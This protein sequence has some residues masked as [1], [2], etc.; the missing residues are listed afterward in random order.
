MAWQED[1]GQGGLSFRRLDYGGGRG[2]ALTLG[3]GGRIAVRSHQMVA[4]GEF[5][6]LVW[7]EISGDD[8]DPYRLNE[9]V[10]FA[11]SDDGG[12]TF[13]Q[14]R[15]ISETPGITSWFPYVAADGPNVAVV[16]QDLCRRSREDCVRS[17]DD[18]HVATS[19]DG[20][21]N[22]TADKLGGAF[23]S[24][25]DVAVSGRDVY[26]TYAS[27]Q[28]KLKLWRRVHDNGTSHSDTK[29]ILNITPN[30]AGVIAIPRIAASEANVLVAL[31]ELSPSSN[32][33]TVRTSSNRG[34][35]FT[36]TQRFGDVEGLDVDAARGMAYVAT[37][38]GAKLHEFRTV[39]DAWLSFG[40]IPVASAAVVDGPW[41]GATDSG[42]VVAWVQEPKPGAAPLDYDIFVASRRHG[43][44]TYT[45][46]DFSVSDA[47]SF[48]PDVAGN[49]DLFG[50][51]WVERPKAADPNGTDYEVFFRPG[52]LGDADLELIEAEA[53]QAPYGA[54]ELVQGKP[55]VVRARV[56]SGFDATVVAP[57]RLTY[58]MEGAERQTKDLTVTLTPGVKNIFLPADEHLLPEGDQLTFEVI[59]DPEGVLEEWDET[60]N[61]FGRSYP[62]KDTRGLKVLVVPIRMGAQAS[63]DCFD[64]AVLAARSQDYVRAAFPV[65]PTEVR[66][67]YQC[68]NPITYDA[69]AE[70]DKI[71]VDI[72]FQRLDALTWGSDY[73]KVVGVVNTGWF[74]KH[75]TELS[76]YREAAGLSPQMSWMDSVLIEQ[77]ANGGWSTA[78]E[79]SHQMGWIPRGHPLADAAKGLTYPGAAR[80][81]TGLSSPG[82]WVERRL[83]LNKMDLMYPGTAGA[84]IAAPDGRW[85]HKETY[86]YLF[87]V[88][89]V[90]PSDPPV[91]GV[92]ASFHEDGTSSGLPFYEFDSFIDAPL[93]SE[94]E[95]EIRYLSAD[96]VTL[97][98][99]GVNG[100]SE[101][102]FVGDGEHAAVDLPFESFSVRIPQVA[103]TQRLA[104][105]RE[106]QVLFERARSSNGP[107]IEM[108]AP[109]S[110][111][112][113]QVGDQ[114][115]LGWAASDED[116]D[117]LSFLVDYS[118]DGGS[119]W[120]PLASDV[121]GDSLTVT[122]TPELVSDNAVVRV[123]VSDGWNTA[124]GVSASFSVRGGGTE[125][126]IAFTRGC[127]DSWCPPPD[128]YVVNPDGS[129]LKQLTST[130]QW[131]GNEIDLRASHP[132][133]SADGTKIAFEGALKATWSS[134]VYDPGIWTI[135]ADG[136]DQR[137]LYR[138]AQSNTDTNLRLVQCPDWSP[139]GR[140]LLVKAHPPPGQLEKPGVY[141]MAADGTDPRKIHTYSG[142]GFDDCPK[143]SSDGRRIV[144]G[145]RVES[146]ND[147]EVFSI[148]ADGTGLRRLTANTGYDFEGAWSPDDS[149][150]AFARVFKTSAGWRGYDIWAMAADGT[151]Q[152]RIT[153]NHTYSG[154]DYPPFDLGPVWSPDGRRLAVTHYT[155]TVLS[156]YD[157]WVIDAA[158]GDR[159]RVTELGLSSEADWGPVSSPTPSE[160]VSLSAEAGGPYEGT[161]GAPI[162]L[163]GSAAGPEGDSMTFDWDLD[164]DGIYGDAT[165]AAVE[166]TYPDDGV[167][168]VGLRAV[169]ASGLIGTDT[170]VVT[171]T[172]AA[173][174]LDDLVATVEGDGSAAI[175]AR[176]SDPGS[177][178]TH[179][180]LVDWGDGTGP[181]A[182]T[183]VRRDDGVGVVAT[184]RY[185]D[186]TSRALTLTATDDDDG[187]AVGH[188]D[189]V[190]QPS[191]QAPEARPGSVTAPEGAP[192]NVNLEAIDPDS[193][194]QPL[195]FSIVSPPAHGRVILLTPSP[196]MSP[197]E[198][199]AVYVPDPDYAG[200]DSFSF[201]A[202]DGEANSNTAD[203]AVT[204][205]RP[206]RAPVCS[207][208]TV[209]P[210]VLWP[211][212]HQLEEVTV[213]GASDPDGDSVNTA[214]AGVTQDEPLNGLGDGDVSPDA[215]RSAATDSVFL[216]A[217][218]SGTGDG[219]VY[220]LSFT[221][222]DPQGASCA[223]TVRVGVPKSS[224]RREPTAVD[225]SLV[226]DSFGP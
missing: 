208:V 85:V 120:L 110:G 2:P 109:Q 38:G 194:P 17:G 33:A 197:D 201:V 8:V 203:V 166:H 69:T 102:T 29:E 138:S 127:G 70:L 189:I 169:T 187:R 90:N 218:R 168:V 39:D 223:G 210:S 41:L 35:T 16:W 148:G 117:A 192:V 142:S 172:N 28:L 4:S 164:G 175:V 132:S 92:R 163:R 66:F 180:A 71:R 50:T 119:T 177:A 211:P 178:D 186:V 207:A 121:T 23:Q 63:P 212:D 174:S 99:A 143:W 225:S 7:A 44:L 219:R 176:I 209:T 122:A 37:R 198:P 146:N 205:T 221:V 144:F 141:V 123:T 135:N 158:T 101:H 9:E 86:Q 149:R 206:N 154:T 93:G 216:R 220:R 51:A 161:E 5:V 94:G 49:Q 25:F 46:T 171:V 96:G 162:S 43:Q 72:L 31:L 131:Q 145:D 128:V 88:L 126:K 155:R 75:T 213:S 91:I 82:Y 53:V 170:A 26:V 12:R 73:D 130:A 200:P 129:G 182:A 83:E 48:G 107:R 59:L 111:D 179:E 114:L 152:V 47:T 56:R 81:V 195:T 14:S 52:S 147:L 24:R 105:A 55:T 139:D 20:G 125:S 226:V 217:E 68:S 32:F 3:G 36:V 185:A 124:R 97:A 65:D 11:A 98:T 137:L 15:R 104:I 136:T 34:S 21:Q 215:Q 204:V 167:F 140:S 224:D 76:E 115:T 153:Q 116:G 106:G 214:V 202:S 62:V 196:L 173:P 64:L 79:L 77:Q 84:D 165:G 112:T 118:T 133:W 87:D 193:G 190:Q 108:T 160:P 159:T 151:A 19:G 157:I 10:W 58:Q 199:D 80:H 6:Y 13:R 40:A 150:I 67:D 191:N 181:Q 100:S 78:H 113:V 57:V 184:H 188:V 222:E 103:G 45:V 183:V 27:P 30:E 61:V 134:T 89:K 22:F 156:D 54:E 42:V 74:A 18:V 1:D 60:N 95:Y